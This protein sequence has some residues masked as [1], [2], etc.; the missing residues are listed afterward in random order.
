[1]DALERIIGQRLQPPEPAQPAA[2]QDPQLPPYTFTIPP[3]LQQMFE[4]ENPA[5]RVQAVSIAMTATAKAVHA[6]VM[7]EFGQQMRQLTESLPEMMSNRMGDFARR[8]SIF[9]DFYGT[10]P[11]L[12]HPGLRPLVRDVT[13]RV[14]Q[15]RGG[16]ENWNPELRDA[17]AREVAMTLQT[18]GLQFVQPAAPPPPQRPNGRAQPP[19]LSGVRGPPA[20]PQDRLSAEILDLMKF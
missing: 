1:M 2:P 4:S 17:I 6:S 13:A 18:T 3:Q 5:D 10:Y 8:Q 15:S 11:Q 12:S 20:T 19:N 14:Y 9:N 16:Q 7:Q